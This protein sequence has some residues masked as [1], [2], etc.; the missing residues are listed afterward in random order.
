MSRVLLSYVL[1]LLLPTAIYFAWA[2]FANSRADKS[3]GTAAAARRTY[4]WFWLA[5]SGF[6]LM[7]T[8]MAVTTFIEGSAPGSTY[9]PPQYRDGVIIPGYFE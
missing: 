3:S 6:V 7:V 4:P 1:P 5:V 9:H 8:V 2:W